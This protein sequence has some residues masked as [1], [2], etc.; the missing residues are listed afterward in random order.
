MNTQVI[1]DQI[2]SDLRQD[3]K[4]NDTEEWFL[5]MVPGRQTIYIYVFFTA[6]DSL[7]V[8]DYKQ[9]TTNNK[10]SFKKLLD[11]KNINALTKY[12]LTYF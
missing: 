12:E 2:A 5:E 6:L 7:H 10:I 8:D 1:N 3:Q 9:N 11:I 4:E